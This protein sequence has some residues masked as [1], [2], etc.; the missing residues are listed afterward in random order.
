[1][2]YHDVLGLAAAMGG[3]ARAATRLDG[4]FHDQNGNWDLS[5]ADPT[6]YDAGN[7]PSIQTPWL[8]NYL[9]K[10]YKTQETLRQILD[11]LWTTGTG[12][13]P[14]N[15]DLGTMSS[16]YLFAAMGLYPQ[17]PS[18]AELVLSA[19]LFT[20]VEIRR[21]NGKTIVIEAP[22]ASAQNKYVQSLRVNDVPSN[23]A[24]VPESLVRDGGRLTYTLGAAPNAGWGASPAD[25][26]PQLGRG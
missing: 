15:D 7:E 19:P 16:W 22:Q 8:Y 4:F 17:I 24:W 12:G 2:V 9:G 1:M 20:R 21:D 23:R 5:G 6:R 11:T 13:I 10:P 14:G 25:V 3:N 18:R 26:P